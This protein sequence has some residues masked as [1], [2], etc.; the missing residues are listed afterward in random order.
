MIFN[1]Y[2]DVLQMVYQEFFHSQSP[3]HENSIE[4]LIIYNYIFQ[5]YNMIIYFI[6]FGH[7]LES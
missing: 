5:I 3:K 4:I 6:T 1:D 7:H 2:E